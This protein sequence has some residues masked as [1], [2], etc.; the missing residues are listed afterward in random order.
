MQQ[1]EI[2][3]VLN[4]MSAGFGV[5][6]FS[7]YC[8]LVLMSGLAWGLVTAIHNALREKGSQGQEVAQGIRVAAAAPCY[9]SLLCCAWGIPARGDLK[10]CSVVILVV[11]PCGN[12]RIFV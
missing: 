3:V 10:Y 7:L 5:S 1:N 4:L 2:G 9:D 12:M 8:H 11:L 6:N